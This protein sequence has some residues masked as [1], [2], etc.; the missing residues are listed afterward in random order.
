MSDP[1]EWTGEGPAPV[2]CGA[3]IAA[4]AEARAEAGGGPVPETCLVVACPGHGVPVGVPCWKPL[5]L[6]FFMRRFAERD[7]HTIRGD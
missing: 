7:H 4:E 1:A 3:R 5:A 2:A 6:S